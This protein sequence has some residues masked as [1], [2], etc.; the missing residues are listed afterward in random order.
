MASSLSQKVI[1]T[2]LRTW[3]SVRAMIP[4]N[5]GSVSLA[6][7]R[8]TSRACRTP[9]SNMWGG[10]PKILIL[11]CICVPTSL[12]PLQ[13][14]RVI[15]F[16]HRHGA[17]SRS[18][19]RTSENAQTAKFAEFQKGEVRRIHLPHTWVDKVNNKDRGLL[20]RL[21]LPS[22]PEQ[23]YPCTSTARTRRRTLYLP[24]TAPR[25]QPALATP[26]TTRR[27]DPL[28]P[29]TLSLSTQGR[30]SSAAPSSAP[31]STSWWAAW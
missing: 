27:L 18:L 10:P 25:I 11:A 15:L 31:S 17:T 5:P 2:I 7:G 14:K 20:R 9:S 1:H 16:H 12:L 23:R 13:L 4:L 22:P 3:R 6:W 28:S 30:R 21:P 19:L 24:P 26:E 8:T 29:S